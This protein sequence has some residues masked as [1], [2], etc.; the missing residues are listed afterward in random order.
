MIKTLGLFKLSIVILLLITPTIAHG[1]AANFNSSDL[2]TLRV[3]DLSDDQVKAFLSRAEDSGMNE[4]QLEQAALAR[5]MLPAEIDKLRA[6]ITKIQNGTDTSSKGN[7]ENPG[8]GTRSY[9]QSNDDELFGN[10]TPSKKAKPEDKIFGFKLFNNK[11]IR[12]E[13]G[14]NIPTPSNYQL[15]VGDEIIIDVWG[16]SQ[17][18]YKLT[19][20]PE[21]SIL[22]N[23][24]GPVVLGGMTIEE[25]TG[26]LKKDLGKIYAGLRGT[27]PNTF[28]KVS[29]GSVRSIKVNIVGEVS[30]P[31]TYTLPSLA[32]IF[33]AL[34]AAGGPSLNGCFRNVK[35]VREGKTIAELDFYE[36][37]LKGELKDNMR[38]QDQDVIFISPYTNRVEAKGEIKRPGLYDLKDN[39]SLKDLVYFTGGYT[40]KAYWQ[41]LVIVRKTGKE[42]KVF[43]I[44]FQE[45]DSFKMANGDLLQVDSILNRYANRVEIKGAVYRPGIFAID[46][47]DSMTLKGIIAKADGLRGD[48]F[49]NRAA[50]YRTKEDLTMEVI[51]VDLNVFM[52]DSTD[53]INLKREDVVDIPSIFDVRE[54][55]FLKIDGEVRKPGLYPFLGNATIE[56]LI[57]KAGGLMES[58]SYARLEIARRIKNN[59][60]DNSSNQIAEIFQFQINQDLK[61]ADSGK[62]F[63]LQPF[64]QVFIRR[65]PGYETQAMVRVDGEVTFPGNYIISNKGEKISDI[66]K[67]AGGLT[68]EAYV[69]G[70]RLIRKLVFDKK[71]RIEALNALSKHAGDTAKASVNDEVAIGIDLDKIL[72]EPGSSFDIILQKGDSIVVPRVLQTVRL[73]G[74]V[75]LPATVRFDKSYDFQ[76]YIA[77]AGGFAPEAAKRKSYVIYANGTAN[78]THKIFFFNHFPRIEPGAEIYVPMKP[79]RK[80]MSAGE[81]ISLSSTLALVIVT[82]INV[83]KSW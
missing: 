74:G 20:S 61:I 53:D 83:V 64:D 72:S 9:L 58:A 65:S 52:A 66:I 8:E 77:R 48:A 73:S 24:I 82:L 79:E 80:G 2:S 67:R 22:I 71:Q 21:G 51:P 27:S 7:T 32:T 26:V 56:D 41:R 69:K 55:Y 25:A 62:K 47:T 5:G 18:T 4:Q 54:D 19:I 30:I 14:L 15:G 40:D 34:Y 36:F 35:L 39:E 49:K 43:D 10:T 16:A 81:I 31:G 44:G 23:N 38:L 50:I 68:P 70:G 46:D 11:K 33:N 78:R 13:P 75:L 60:A 57:V 3:D 28:L 42:R 17:Q 29:I 12:F 59:S 45:A 76:S 6:R 1:Q 37:L 63:I